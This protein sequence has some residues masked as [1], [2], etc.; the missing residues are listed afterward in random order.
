MLKKYLNYLKKIDY[1]IATIILTLL[2][3]LTVLGVVMRYVFNK[4]F[5]WLEEV[6]LFCMVWLVFFGAAPALRSGS[7]VAIEIV[8]ELFPIG[9]QKIIDVF[10]DLIFIGVMSF[11]FYQSIGFIR[12]FILNARTTPMLDIPMWFVYLAAPIA[13]V[14]I[15]L[16]HIWVTYTKLIVQKKAVSKDE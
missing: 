1:L 7:L 11:F 13:S 14:D 10:I 5:T 16:S 3:V 2:V 8:V 15:I 4:P 12:M 9:I 6:Q